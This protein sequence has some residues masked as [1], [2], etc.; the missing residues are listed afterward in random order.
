MVEIESS[1]CRKYRESSRRWMVKWMN[2]PES[3]CLKI[4]M[5]HTHEF[6]GGQNE[7]CQMLKAENF[8][9]N[10]LN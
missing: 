1:E 10:W 4:K 3:E 7:R 5:Q 9:A 8:L 2:D 6:I